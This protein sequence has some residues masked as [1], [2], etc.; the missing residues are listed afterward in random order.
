MGNAG[1][2]SSTVVRL[3]AGAYGLALY[4]QPRVQL[5]GVGLL[6]LGFRALFFLRV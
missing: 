1:S 6:A 4:V 3:A 5:V 2:I